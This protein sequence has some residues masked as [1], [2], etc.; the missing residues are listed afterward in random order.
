MSTPAVVFSLGFTYDWAI[1]GYDFLEYMDRPEAF[2]KTRHLNDEYKDFIDYMSNSE[3]SDGLFNAQSD[4]LTESDK[5]KYRQLETVSRDAGCPKYY[6]VVSFDNN[7][8]IENGLMTSDGK[9]DVHGIKELGREGINA[10][11]STSNKLDNDNVYWTGAIHT[12]T[13][14][15]HIHFSICEYERREDRCKVYRDKDCIEV[16]AFDKLKSK[17]VN[18][19][20]G[21]DYSRQLTELERESIKPA[22]SSGYGGCAEQLIRL[23]DK[24][25]SEGGWQYGRPKMRAYRDDIDKTVDAVI[26]S[27]PQLSSLWKQYNDMLDSRTEYLRKI[28]GEGERHL[29]ATFKPNRLE[30]FHKELGNQLLDDLAPL[31]EQL[32][33][34]ALPQAHPSENENSEQFLPPQYDE[35][36]DVIMDMPEY[37]QPNSLDEEYYNSLYAS[38]DAHPSEKETK[39]QLRIE[40]SDRYKQALDL[41]YGSR[42][43]D[44][45]ELPKDLPAALELLAQESDSGNVLAT[46]DLG[47]LYH[48]MS[49]ENYDLSPL[50]EQN[51]IEALDGFQKLLDKQLPSWQHSYLCYRVGKMYDKGLG[52]VQDYKAAR[53]YYEKAGENRFAYFSLGNMYKFGS[54]VDVDMTMAVSYY[55]KALACKGDMPFASFNIGQAYE[56]GQGVKA[57]EQKAAKYYAQ[58]LAGFT[59]IYE[60][61]HEDSISYRLGTMYL[62]GKGTDVDLKKAEKYLLESAD[63]GNNQAQYQL[64]KLRLAQ[65]RIDEAEQLFI[66]SAEKG[67]VYSA[68]ALGRIYMTEEKRDDSKAEQFLKQYLAGS[69][70]EL[71]IGE[72]A[73]GK[74]YI[75]QDHIDEAEQ[76]FI[77][78]A[79]KGNVYSA[80]SLGR[81]YMTEEKRDDSKAEQFL[82]Q[83]LAGSD[84]ELGIGEYALGKLYLTQDHIDEAEQLFIKSAGKGNAYSA[85]SLG[86][87]YMTEEKRDD[88]KAEQFLKQYLAGS[89]DELGIGEYAL[90]KF[91]LS[92]DHIDEAEQLFIKS[93]EK[94]NAY[95]A[96]SLGRIYMTEEKQDDSKA[97][98][99]L[100]QYLAG[101][102]DELGIGEYALGKLYLSQDRI[103]EAEQ[104]L[105]SSSEKENLYASYKLGKLYLTDRK[106]DYT[107]AVK[108]L[109]P[110]ADKADNEYA[111]YALGCIYLKKEHYDRRLAEKYLLESSGHN[112]SSAQLK[113]GLMYREEQKYRQSDYWMKLAAQ[114]GNEYAQKILAER[115]EQI[116]M[117]LHLGATA[118]SVMRRVCSNMQTKAQQLLA[119]VERDE[120]EQKYKQAISQ[121]YSR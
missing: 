29:Y 84:D 48:I 66:K 47:K 93:A 85:F 91:Y 83:Y 77:K 108:Y 24:L 88:S 58:A 54:G 13:D 63:N 106:L 65:D 9:L 69:D 100:K 74:L 43:A 110:C 49:D 95:S 109:K 6:G 79:G 82:K 113:L 28:Y 51:Y 10:M 57:D 94:G 22:L 18:R 34:S 117:K 4:L 5:E 114:N 92:Q 20:L 71:G 104:L 39:S 78:S 70:D 33:A 86:R 14:N 121:T 111:Q 64:G 112:N 32:R 73:L 26:A 67:N 12:N 61:S 44:G 21:S 35:D 2:D 46:Y 62:K 45:K 55:E 102:D 50:S 105:I 96:F 59:A 98:Q 76:L 40:W 81:I 72:Y 7:F 25:P 8:L 37:S 87:I 103:D 80:F 60:K 75:S 42:T 23:A 30:D 89:D 116:R 36:T 15:I 17:I 31:A 68:F 53:E 19:V 107:K 90:G 52:T 3:K 16:K 38:M 56:L 11:I 115:H 99:F 118:N 41:M 97:E 120:Q 27:D 1:G 101:S 119:Q